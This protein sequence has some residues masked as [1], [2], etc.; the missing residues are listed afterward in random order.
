LAIIEIKDLMKKKV[1][2]I[3][4][5]TSGIG[6]SLVSIFLDNEIKV[7]TFSRNKK[8]LD[9]LVKEFKNDKDLLCLQADVTSPKDIKKIF[10]TIKKKHKRLDFLVNNSGLGIRAPV[11]KLKLNEWKK[12]IDTNLTGVFLLTT[13][14]LPLLKKDSL[15]LNIGSIASKIGFPNWSAYCASK[16]G[17]KGFTEAL[18]EELRPKKIKVVHAEIGPT[19]TRFWKQIK[20]WKPDKTKMI[21][22]SEVASVLFDSITNK[23]SLNIDEISL[24]PPGGIL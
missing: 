22:D 17:L 14:F 2:L 5:G 20:G 19:S 16:F 7:I 9:Q 3:S 18:R 13:T 1:A 8:N 15:I 12:I 6:K 11:A 10:S 4:G 21:K 24:M 23:K